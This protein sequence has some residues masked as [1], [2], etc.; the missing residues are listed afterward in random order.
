MLPLSHSLN[1]FYCI[2]VYFI[3][4][5]NYILLTAYVV[6]VILDLSPCTH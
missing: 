6:T 4:L 2:T 3:V 5:P 1:V